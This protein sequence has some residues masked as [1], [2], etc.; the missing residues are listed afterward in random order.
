[1]TDEG[2]FANDA[3]LGDPLLIAVQ[4][5]RAEPI[6]EDVLDRVERRLMKRVRRAMS[7]GPSRGAN[8]RRSRLRVVR[9]WMPVTSAGLAA[10]LLLAIG[11]YAFVFPAP[12]LTL[13]EVQSALAKQEWVLLKYEDGE[14][15]WVALRDG[16]RYLKDPD[17]RVQ[18]FA[19]GVW[20]Q[21]L[22][23]GG[24]VDLPAS[25][26]ITESRATAEQMS[27][28]PKW[29]P[30]SA[31]Q[32]LMGQI[33]G[34]EK[35]RKDR[36]H[37]YRVEKAV[38]TVDGQELVRFNIIHTNALDED[39]LHSQIWADPKTQLPV[40][41]RKVRSRS[42]GSR[43]QFVAG[44]YS[45]PAT[46]P[47]DIYDLGVPSDAKILRTYYG[48][49]A[50]EVAD[51]PD[52]GKLLA[53][54]EKSRDEFPGQ[55]RIV[56]WPADFTGNTI[57]EIDVMYWNGRPAQKRTGK[58]SFRDWTG[59]K[60]RQARYGSGFG[61][62]RFPADVD[63]VLDWVAEQMPL[64]LYVS[65]GKRTFTQHNRDEVRVRKIARDQLSTIAFPKNCWPSSIYWPY[66]GMGGT[67]ELV[68]DPPETIDGTV[69]L[70]MDFETTR[71][72]FYIAP[73]RDYL[74]VKQVWWRQHEDDWRKDREYELSDFRKL[75]SGQWWVAKH[76]VQSHNNPL[77]GNNIYE[78]VLKIDI[79]TMKDDGFPADAFDTKEL[80]ERA[81]QSGAKI[82]A[83]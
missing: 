29:T 81:R 72:D 48:V 20:Q 44:S 80:L 26:R 52:V 1:M 23:A 74:C 34:I 3:D 71:L 16:R 53:E 61:N 36:D 75:P 46:G 38:E 30:Q 6:S 47:K 8:L 17:G 73:M 4:S 57:D 65:D 77:R 12:Q 45:F 55:Y 60:V 42:D 24:P 54:A 7:T 76:R 50:R 40:R 67:K 68:T 64:S 14:E 33:E 39:E 66:T 62:L 15:Y 18:H 49:G 35:A 59:V 63:Q 58:R 70:R 2:V 11:L 51:R 13:A 82:T 19:P 25:G 9:R 41:S 31:W 21:Y 78:Q 69:L 79:S 32:F 28:L 27:K 37:P 10:C 43:G 22:P 5:I 83:D 56:M